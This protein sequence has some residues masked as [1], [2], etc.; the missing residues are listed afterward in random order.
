LR[1][2]WIISAGIA[3]SGTMAAAQGQRLPT[4][5][6]FAASMQSKLPIPTSDGGQVVAVAAEG[7]TVI[8]T[9]KLPDRMVV[10][11]TPTE[12]S[13]AFRHGLCIIDFG[14]KFFGAGYS[15]RVDASSPGQSV[16]RGNVIT[17]CS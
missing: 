2:S 8:Y 16:R 10:G 1:L 11:H 14:E 5:A 7:N 12:I 4:P 3:V 6:E 15:I 17:G 9:L 13:N